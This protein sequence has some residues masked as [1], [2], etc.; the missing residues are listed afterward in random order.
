MAKAYLLGELNW[1]M[2]DMGLV[3]VWRAMPIDSS[4]W[5]DWDGFVDATYQGSTVGMLVDQAGAPFKLDLDE[6][7]ARLRARL[8]DADA[9]CW[10]QLAIAWRAA[11]DLGATG[12]LVWFSDPLTTAYRAVIGDYSSQWEKL[13]AGDASELAT[14]ADLFGTTKQPKAAAKAKPAAMK[15][16]SAKPATKAKAKPTTKPAAKKSAVK[17]KSAASAKPAK[18]K[19]AAKKPS[20]PAKKKKKR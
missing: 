10:Q 17:A 16:K 11:A 7:G 14:N 9:P 6:K 3:A 2:P 5:T 13:S 1:P 20:K 18:A 12:E 19:P 8:S 15:A 4:R